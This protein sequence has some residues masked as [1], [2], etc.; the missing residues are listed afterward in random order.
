MRSTIHKARIARTEPEKIRAVVA[1]L[2][3]E[4]QQEGVELSYSTRQKCLFDQMLYPRR[5]E[6]RQFLCV[7]IV[8]RE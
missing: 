8:E 2:L 6:P 1:S 4:R 3:I 7:V 5:L